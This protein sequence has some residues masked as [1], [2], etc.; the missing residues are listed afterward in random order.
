MSNK[1]PGLV[2]AISVGGKIQHTLSGTNPLEVLEPTLAR[3]RADH[4]DQLRKKLAPA[5]ELRANEDDL[6]R[7]FYF[8]DFVPLEGPGDISGWMI[9]FPTEVVL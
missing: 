2:A 3:V 9:V 1:K 6:L 8:Q 5:I 7:G 4:R